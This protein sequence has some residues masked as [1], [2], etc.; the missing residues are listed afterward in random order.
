MKRKFFKPN[1]NDGQKAFYKI[2]L[3]EMVIALLFI[4]FGVISLLNSL[5]SEKTIAVSLGI[6]IL[7]EGA[8]NIYSNVMPH[9]NGEYKMNVI[10]AILYFIIALLLFTNIIKFINYIQI[11][12]G[13]YL[14]ISGIKYLLIAIKLKKMNDKGFLLVLS[15]SILLIALGGLLVFYPYVSFTV[16]ELI[17]IFSILVGL[18]NLNNANLLRNRADVIIE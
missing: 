5:M 4:L 16:Y 13:A 11:Y 18:L 10:F 8:L 7:I 6:L 1:L 3:Y 17:A 2:E 15:M 9:N 14:A 12:Y